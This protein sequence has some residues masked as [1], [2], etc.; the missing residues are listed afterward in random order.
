MQKSF[1]PTPASRPPIEQS[2]DNIF[3][4]KQVLRQM[5]NPISVKKFNELVHKGLIPRIDL[6]HRTKR[7]RVSAVRQAL[8]ALE[9]EV[10]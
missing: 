6:G 7:Y 4:R 2:P 5:G 8:I 9:S 10:S 3:T 1:G